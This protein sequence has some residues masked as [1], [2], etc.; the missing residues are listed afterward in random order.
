M[1][2]W[3]SDSLAP[4]Y[5]V[6]GLLNPLKMLPSKVTKFAFS[7]DTTVCLKSPHIISPNVGDD[8]QAH[9]FAKKYT[10]FYFYFHR[11]LMPC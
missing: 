2:Y 6:C 3:A 10:I 9:F 1:E 7:R 4:D 5:W 11:I 8:T